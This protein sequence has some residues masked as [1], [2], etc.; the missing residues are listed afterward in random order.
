VAEA[1]SARTVVGHGRDGCPDARRRHE[2][3]PLTLRTAIRVTGAACAALLL[4]GVGGA[5]ADRG[6]SPPGVTSTAP[7]IPVPANR[8][9][10]DGSGTQGAGASTTTTTAPSG[11]GV[12]ATDQAT[13]ETD[14]LVANDLGG[15]YTSLPD[16]SAP[17]LAGSGCLAGLGLPP[18]G[19]VRAVQ[20]L[21]GPFGQDLP[22]ID[23]Q[24]TSYPTAARA[25]GAFA[26]LD[27]VLT[28][29]TSTSLA[30][31]AGTATA[32]LAPFAVAGLGDQAV[33]AQ[34]PFHLGS[35]VGKVTVS[36]VRLSTTV[37]VFVFADRDPP[38]LA[39]LGTPQSTLR[40]AVGKASP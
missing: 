32:T 38:S 6:S 39:I 31:A 33:T 3:V 23:E 26:T 5:V 24:L 19:E 28:G 14:L 21:R 4:A 10:G 25:A 20:Y 16:D 12:A 35:L 30:I 34:G 27:R 29:C 37:V 22:D 1:V 9:P 18:A 11:D 7:G 13:L 36:V 15:Y 40:A 8:G 17:R 2:A